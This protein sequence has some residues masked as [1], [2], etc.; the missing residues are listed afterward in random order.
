MA[1][2]EKPDLVLFTGPVLLK[3]HFS[4]V[5]WKRRTAIVPVRAD[6]DISTA[7]R[8][9]GQKGLRH[10]V[11]RFTGKD[12]EDFQKIAIA[13]WS[14]GG[15][16]TDA[17]LRDPESRQQVSA[18]VLNDALFGSDHAGIAEFL[19]EAADG[20][21]LLV[22]TNTNNRASANIPKRARESV[23]DL[24]DETEVRLTEARS[25]G[26]MPEPSGGVWQAGDFFWYDYVQPNGQND[27]SHAEHHDL[28]PVTW[29]AHLA[30]HLG[31]SKFPVFL[32]MAGAASLIGV[33]VW[34]SAR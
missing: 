25:R 26:K 17:V 11:K 15:S 8:A 32:A 1:L 19:G 34:K 30:P 27:I 22:I 18:V 23:T 7:Y 16:L 24:L 5:D 29:D 12:P 21:K 20:E 2:P 31:R 3:E 9:L 4:D 14:K 10:I 13:A 6:Q 28:A 33:A